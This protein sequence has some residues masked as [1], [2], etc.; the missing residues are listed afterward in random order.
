MKKLIMLLLLSIPLCCVAQSLNKRIERAA[1]RVLAQSTVVVEAKLAKPVY[2]S[3][4]MYRRPRGK[5]VVIRID[6]KQAQCRGRLSAQQTQVYVPL[7]CVA[8]D[9][10]KAA[11]VFITFSDG[12][13][14]HKSGKHVQYQDE[15][16]LIR[17]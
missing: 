5:D 15:I 12:K 7:S 10:Y 2:M 4:V 16:A 13:K 6:Y 11:E 9:D 17:I 1:A 8:D 3:D 14:I